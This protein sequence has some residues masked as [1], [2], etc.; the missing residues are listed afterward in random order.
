MPQSVPP[1]V[2]FTYIINRLWIFSCCPLPKLRLWLAYGRLI[3][4]H[5]FSYL[6][7]IHSD[8][9][10]VTTIETQAR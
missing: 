10:L 6:N 5:H 2:F 7:A 4:A 3:L 1:V 9:V 8:V